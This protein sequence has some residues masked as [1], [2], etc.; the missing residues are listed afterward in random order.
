MHG[1]DSLRAV[2]VVRQWIDNIIGGED[3]PQAIW[4]AYEDF[5]AAMFDEMLEK[6]FDAIDIEDV[7]TAKLIKLMET[8]VDNRKS[9][10][11]GGR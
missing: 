1:N 9:T 3:G 2:R 10:K 8:F 11:A 7:Q 4:A 6:G 5:N